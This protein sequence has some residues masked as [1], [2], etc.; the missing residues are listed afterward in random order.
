MAG[1]DFYRDTE[2]DASIILNFPKGMPGVL[3]ALTDILASKGRYVISEGA[4][5]VD[6]ARQIVEESTGDPRE[7]HEIVSTDPAVWKVLRNPVNEDTL[8][9][10]GVFHGRIPP[11]V[12]ENVLLIDI[13]RSLHRKVAKPVVAD[14]SSALQTKGTYPTGKTEE[15][16]AGILGLCYEVLYKPEYRLFKKDVADLV[17]VA[18]A[19]D[20]MYNPPVPLEDLSMKSAISRFVEAIHGWM[21]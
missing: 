13:G 3:S 2:L 7:Y 8:R 10:I 18:T 20:F 4:I 16:F 1:F 15:V 5:S 6:R 12:P 14:I 17:P 19:F 11:E 9:V 21:G